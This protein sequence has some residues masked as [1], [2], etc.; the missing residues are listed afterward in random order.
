MANFCPKIRFLRNFSLLG[1]LPSSFEGL[2]CLRGSR[3]NQHIKFKS[4]SSNDWCLWWSYRYSYIWVHCPTPTIAH[5]LVCLW[6]T[7]I[8]CYKSSAVWVTICIL[9]STRTVTSTREQKGENVRIC[10]APRIAQ[11]YKHISGWRDK[12]YRCASHLQATNSGK[13]G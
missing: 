2:F 10:V 8:L 6:T 9:N 7:T 1:A 13:W 12:G 5:N 4:A 11:L 3:H